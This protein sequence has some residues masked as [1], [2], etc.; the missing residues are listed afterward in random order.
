MG[1]R[2]NVTMTVYE[3]HYVEQNPKEPDLCTDL[4]KSLNSSNTI[5]DRLM[6]LTQNEDN[7]DSDFIT[8]FSSS[9]GFLFGSFARLTAGEESVVPKTVLDKKT[10]SLNDMISES[11]AS[12]EGSIRY[13]SFFCIYKNLIILT[14]RIVTLKA[15][16]TYVNW[17]MEQNGFSSKITFIPKKNTAT[18]L[19]VKEI[20][21]VEIAEGYINAR[22]ETKTQSINLKDNLLKMLL[23]VKGKKDFDEENLISAKLTLKFKQKEI[24]KEKNLNAALKIIDDENIIIIGKNGKRIRGSQYLITAVRKIEK[25]KSGIFNE[26]EIE[27]E[28]RKVLKDINNGKVVS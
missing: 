11:S 3:I 19:P 26:Q 28:M 12:N 10:V 27:T 25:L 5:R 23:D 17:L 16:Q 15:L 14:N 2:N 21:S 20:K 18:E 7:T 8:T 13:S 9:S 6:P 22:N 4:F 1:N 24:N